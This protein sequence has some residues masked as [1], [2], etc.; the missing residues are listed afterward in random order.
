MSEIIIGQVRFLLMTSLL[1]MALMGAYD[2]CRFLRW[3]IPHHGVMVALGDILFWVAASVPAYGMFYI[4]NDGEIRWYGALAVLLGGFLY[5]RG[6]SMPVRRL[7]DRYLSAPKRKIIGFLGR[8][9]RKCAGVLRR[10]AKRIYSARKKEGDGEEEMKKQEEISGKKRKNRAEK[11][12]KNEKLVANIIKI[13]Y[14]KRTRRNVRKALFY[15]GLR[16]IGRKRFLVQYIVFENM[17]DTIYCKKWGKVGEMF[18]TGGE[19]D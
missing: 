3:I 8:S 16:G 18:C 11:S 13:V 15:K 12:H 14:S 1:G 4:Y 7:G 19:N 6:I 10:G 5:E 2:V 9:M 17:T